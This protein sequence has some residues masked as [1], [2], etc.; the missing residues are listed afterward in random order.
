[1]RLLETRSCT[2]REFY[3]CDVPPYAILSHTW[4]S[5]EVSFQDLT[6]GRAASRSGIRKITQCC[7]QAV[8]DGL[9]YVVGHLRRSWGQPRNYRPYEPS[10][11]PSPPSPLLPD[12][13]PLPLQFEAL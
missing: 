9:D 6:E 4:T 8:S 10:S 2:L 7:K 11:P 12:T 1:M 5:G 3:H 13:T